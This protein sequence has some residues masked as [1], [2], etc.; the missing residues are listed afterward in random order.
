MRV[1]RDHDDQNVKR[2]AIV[3]LGNMGNRWAIEFLEMLA[4]YFLAPGTLL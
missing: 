1:Y 4:P 2:L 3:A